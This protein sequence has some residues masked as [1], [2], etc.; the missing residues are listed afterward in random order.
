MNLGRV[1]GESLHA[2]NRQLL[3]YPKFLL[4]GVVNAAV[5]LLVLNAFL[6]I[7]PTLSSPLLITYNSVAVVCAI[8]T[9]YVLNRS[10]TFRDRATN[11]LRERAL[12]WLQGGV[13][14]LINDLILLF[15]SHYIITHL[16]FPLMVS[17]NVAK[18]VAMASSSSVSY[19]VLHFIV[20]R[21]KHS[22]DV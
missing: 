9:G 15:L 6:F 11:S 13:N 3:R 19:L 2:R 4:V 12:F 22:A 17:S 16:H 8:A 1:V 10:W 20:F 5:D 18:A 14:V 21:H 7:H